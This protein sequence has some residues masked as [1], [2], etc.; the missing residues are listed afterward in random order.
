LPGVEEVW[1]ALPEARVVGGAV[2]DLLA[3]RAVADVD[4]AVPLAPEVVSARLAAAGIKVV[5]TGIAHGTVTA[6]VGEVGFEVT[7][8]RR[9][10]ATDGRRAVVEFIDDWEAD[11]ARRDFTINAMSMDRDG[12]IFDYFGGRADLVAGVVRFV[13]TARERIAEDYLRILRFFRFFARYGGV[14]DETA[15]AAIRELRDAVLGLSAERVWR[16]LKRIVAADDPRA[17]VRLMAQTGVLGLVVPEGVN[18][19]RFEK[20]V[21]QGGA[22]DGLLRVA[23]LLDGDV[24]GF[25]ERLK[26]STDELA[27]L[28]AVTAP[29]GLAPGSGDA[30]VR[31]ALAD[32]PADILLARSA[33]ARDEA[34][35]WDELRLRLRSVTRPVLPLQGR[36]LVAMGVAPGPVVG[37]ILAAVR[38]WWMAGGCLA[39][40][41]SCKARARQMLG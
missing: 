31:R 23:A 24:E 2:R 21:G 15:V 28:V 12:E 3:R 33:L 35:G 37:E 26:I 36:D 29:L 17:A 1:A 41:E 39:D 25:G 40:S 18:L 7:A 6:V 34:A 32:T 8:L 16:E 19:A 13:G 27:F 10:V 14:P 20:V 9:D 38:A 11:A 22:V 5:P 30:D 4:F